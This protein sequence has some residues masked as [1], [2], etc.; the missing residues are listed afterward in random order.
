MQVLL[1]VG[2]NSC[3][4]HLSSISDS[5]KGKCTWELI[6]PLSHHPLSV[7]LVKDIIQF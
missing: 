7:T 1:Q 3:F 2:I 4:C 6:F 5:K